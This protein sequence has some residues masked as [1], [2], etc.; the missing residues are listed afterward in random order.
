[1]TDK[2]LLDTHSVSLEL[3]E[4]ELWTRP[5][6]YIEELKTVFI[7]RNLSEADRHQV[8]LHELGHLNHTPAIYAMFTE[9]AEVQANRYM[10]HNLIEEEL[11]TIDDPANFNLVDFANKYH[12]NT[13]CFETI[14]ADE[15]SKMV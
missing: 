10:I 5:G 4:G 2:E 11:Q 1:M 3:F 13:L 14:I 9:K 8:L 15:Y 6:I 7:N 12:L